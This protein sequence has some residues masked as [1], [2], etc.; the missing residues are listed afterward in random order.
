MSGLTKESIKLLE[1][2]LRELQRKKELLKEEK[3]KLISQRDLSVKRKEDLEK[4]L[5]DKAKVYGWNSLE[6]I[7][8]AMSSFDVKDMLANL[9]Q[10]QLL[11]KE[12]LEEIKSSMV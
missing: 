1:S 2:E 7:E 11:V 10:R 9:K 3:I 5:L 8:K 6:E 12:K 4:V